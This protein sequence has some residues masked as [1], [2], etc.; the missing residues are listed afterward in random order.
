MAPSGP[1]PMSPEVRLSGPSQVR[2][3]LTGSVAA[4]DGA[5]RAVG[6]PSGWASVVA[7]EGVGSRGGSA[8]MRISSSMMAAAAAGAAGSSMGPARK[9]PAGKG[10]VGDGVPGQMLGARVVTTPAGRRVAGESEGVAK[11]GRMD[12]CGKRPWESRPSDS[13]AQ[14]ELS[15][16]SNHAEGACRQRVQRQRW[17][18]VARRAD[19]G[20]SS[21]EEACRGLAGRWGRQFCTTLAKGGR[22]RQHMTVQKPPAVEVG[23]WKDRDGFGLRA[24]C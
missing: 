2:M 3:P 15:D 8:E 4:W 1:L 18:G 13:F 7:R 23:Y 6:S 21:G 5:R 20:S 17:H 10:V 22:G 19:A 16:T 14:D 24:C 11:G 12:R 9:T